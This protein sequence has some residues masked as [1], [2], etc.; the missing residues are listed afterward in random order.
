MELTKLEYAQIWKMRDDRA[1]IV[2]DPSIEDQVTFYLHS[3]ALIS[4]LSK[5]QF[6]KQTQCLISYPTESDTTFQ[7]IKAGDVIISRGEK[8]VV[9]SNIRKNLVALDHQGQI[10]TIGSIQPIE[11][12]SNQTPFEFRGKQICAFG[13]IYK[14]N[15]FTNFSVNA[16]PVADPSREA[17]LD[18]R[19]IGALDEIQF[20]GNDHD[21]EEAL[22][23]GIPLPNYGHLVFWEKLCDKIEGDL[24]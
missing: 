13:A 9:V 18:W 24:A 17:S 21:I 4:S 16:T 15:N 14:V 11:I 2:N 19:S 5:K 6:R 10:H 1:I 20:V 8:F 3:S 22:L 7:R 23:S 12:I